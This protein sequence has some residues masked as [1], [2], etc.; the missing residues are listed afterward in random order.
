MTN[1]NNILLF[2]VLFIICGYLSLAVAG[3]STFITPDEPAIVFIGLLRH[4]WMEWTILSI[5]FFSVDV[6]VISRYKHLFRVKK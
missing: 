6:F 3:L 5:A 1:R 4:P 2:R